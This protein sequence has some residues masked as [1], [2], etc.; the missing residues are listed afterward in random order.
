MASIKY[1]ASLKCEF[2]FRNGKSYLSENVIFITMKKK[3]NSNVYVPERVD[4]SYGLFSKYWSIMIRKY[5]WEAGCSANTCLTCIHPFIIRHK[6]N[7]KLGP[8]YLNIVSIVRCL[9]VIC[10]HKTQDIELTKFPLPPHQCHF[11]IIRQRHHIYY[12]DTRDIRLLSP[13]NLINH[14]ILN[15]QP[16]YSNP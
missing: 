10:L 14:L 4:T 11:L 8:T 12:N 5:V 15:L 9:T 6:R 3:F 1:F 2:F 16:W 13:L 7:G